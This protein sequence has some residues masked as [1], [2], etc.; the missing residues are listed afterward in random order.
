MKWVAAAI[1]K[2]L[3]LAALLWAGYLLIRNLRLLLA[4]CLKIKDLFKKNLLQTSSIPGLSKIG[5]IR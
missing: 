3:E 1:R 5:P 4:E 2:I